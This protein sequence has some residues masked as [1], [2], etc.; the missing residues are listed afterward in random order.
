M[1]TKLARLGYREIFGTADN[2]LI[3]AEEQAKGH[4]FHYSKYSG[5]HNTDL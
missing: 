2:F 3:G 4:E 5:S 1:Q